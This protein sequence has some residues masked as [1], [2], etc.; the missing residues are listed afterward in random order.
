M[1]KLG[2]NTKKLNGCKRHYVKEFQ[3]TDIQEIKSRK[4][5]MEDY[6]SF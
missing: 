4:V 2:Y 3:Y 1:K 6:S 5:L